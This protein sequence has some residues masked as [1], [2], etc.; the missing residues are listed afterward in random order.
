[1]VR[2]G[3]RRQGLGFGGGVGA[4]TV[5]RFASLAGIALYAAL[6]AGFLDHLI[7]TVHP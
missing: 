3:Q 1:M 7:G 4:M 5:R 2:V 6:M